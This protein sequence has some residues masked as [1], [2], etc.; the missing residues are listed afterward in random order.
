MNKWQVR[1]MRS[2][3]GRLSIGKCSDCWAGGNGSRKGQG[4]C[5]D[6]KRIMLELPQRTRQS[7]KHLGGKCHKYNSVSP[8]RVQGHCKNY[9]EVSA[10]DFTQLQ[11]AKYFWRGCRKR[12]VKIPI[13]D[14][15][16]VSDFHFDCYNISHFSSATYTQTSI[17]Q[18]TVFIKVKLLPLECWLKPR[19]LNL[20]L[21]HCSP[22]SPSFSCSHTNHPTIHTSVCVIGFPGMDP[23]VSLSP[24][25]KEYPSMT[26]KAAPAGPAAL[27]RDLLV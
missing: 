1:I 21:Q 16:T 11:T 12:K 9:M 7:G 2:R 24:V 17:G 4:P 6:G 22:S 10:I 15:S 3:P 18:T 20:N 14:T 13:H 5:E 19:K 26:G 8:L 25:M 23:G 27:W